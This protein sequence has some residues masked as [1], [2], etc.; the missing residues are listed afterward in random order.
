MVETREVRCHEDCA[1]RTEGMCETCAEDHGRGAARAKRRDDDEA[2]GDA[3]NDEAR[4]ERMFHG[5][6][7]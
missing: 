3:L 1:P 7:V 6:G 5:R 2:R 4:D